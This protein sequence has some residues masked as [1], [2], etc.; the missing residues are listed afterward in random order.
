MELTISSNSKK[1]LVVN[2]P[3]LQGRLFNLRASLLLL[4]SCLKA[5]IYQNFRVLSVSTLYI[6]PSLSYD[7]LF[8]KLLR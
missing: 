8:I 7:A 3:Y 2:K 4:K 6:L 5:C 1:Q